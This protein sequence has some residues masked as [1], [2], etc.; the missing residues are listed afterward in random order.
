MTIDLP[1]K[2]FP[3]QGAL[4][5]H[6][7]PTQ[8]RPRTADR[9]RP[10]DRF[11]DPI[12]QYRVRYLAT[13]LRGALI[14]VCNHWRR[15][16]PAEDLLSAVGHVVGIDVL[17]EQPAGLIPESWLAQQ[18][19]A[20]GRIDEGQF[21][22]VMNEKLLADLDRTSKS[23]RKALRPLG[24]KQTLDRGTIQLGGD[25]GRRITQAV[26]RQLYEHPR[27]PAGISYISRF[28]EN[29]ECWSVFDDRVRVVFDIETPFITPLDS[30]H[31]EA[32]CA[33]ATLLG[34][35]L[36]PSWGTGSG[37]EREAG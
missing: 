16:Q 1:F 8:L 14:E 10:R 12:G 24:G 33:A 5:V 26:S 13:T 27:T 22:D 18:R 23:V 11:D 37:L 25:M 36:P 7:A 4:R 6:R 28:T 29:E 3:L 2:V 32:V 15:S 19:V 21:V 20:C 31:L 9:E 17:E 34:L 30:A 35:T